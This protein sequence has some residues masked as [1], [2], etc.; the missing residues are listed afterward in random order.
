MSDFG[1]AMILAANFFTTLH[2]VT[3]SDQ[4]YC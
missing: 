1:I 2:H 4:H 3:Q